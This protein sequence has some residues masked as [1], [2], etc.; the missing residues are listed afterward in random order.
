M[1]LLISTDFRGLWPLNGNN[2]NGII[3][4]TIL[5]QA[6]TIVQPCVNGDVTFPWEW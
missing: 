4:I 3:I 1:K 5:A 2:N 6:R